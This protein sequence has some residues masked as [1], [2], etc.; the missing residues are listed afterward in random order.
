M[1]AMTAAL[2]SG[3][4]A[5]S[6]S[7]Y[8]APLK[9]MTKMEGPD[10]YPDREGAGGVRMMRDQP[11]A[12]FLRPEKL[13][14]LARSDH[15]DGDFLMRGVRA[16]RGA[17]AAVFKPARIPAIVPRLP[18]IKRLATDPKQA[19]H[20]KPAAVPKAKQ[21]NTLF[22]R[23]AFPE[24]HGHTSQEQGMNHGCLGSTRSKLSAISPIWTGS[25]RSAGPR[26]ME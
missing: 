3:E 24:R 15:N 18:K 20:R 22:H 23:I 1:R 11:A 7:S 9:M 25:S 5:I 8:P 26:R 6:S 19:R 4:Y 21:P 12:D 2:R 13:E 16:A 10:N 17:M 14:P